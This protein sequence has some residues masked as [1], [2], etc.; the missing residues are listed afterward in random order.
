[1]QRAQQ[2]GAPGQL[3]GQP[4][5][6]GFNQPVQDPQLVVEVQDAEGKP[7]AIAGAPGFSA[8][9]VQQAAAA[10]NAAL[11]AAAAAAQVS[12]G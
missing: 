11:S 4:T 10:A 2:S 3:P 6:Q 5:G 9:P 1:M 12:N 7:G 8:N